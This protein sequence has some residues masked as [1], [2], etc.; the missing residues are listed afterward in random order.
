MKTLTN[1]ELLANLGI[2]TNEKVLANLLKG[3]LE[4][5]PALTYTEQVKVNSL[6][7]IYKRIAIEKI[8]KKP[9]ITSAR[10]AAEL[11]RPFMG[12]L[13]HEEAWA[14]YCDGARK[15]ITMKKISEGGL[16]STTVDIRRVLRWA[17]RLGSCEIFIFH[18]HPS[19]DAEPGS[20]DKTLTKTLRDACAMVDIIL[21]DH[22]VLANNE[23]F[24]FVEEGLL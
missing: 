22:I 9:T 13:N 17:I 7:E 2:K 3:R 6:K 24:S 16:N 20:R 5:S 1:Q 14:M 10:Q 18:N 15:V 11:A 4:D 8:E 23:Y 21:T 12:Y 19:G